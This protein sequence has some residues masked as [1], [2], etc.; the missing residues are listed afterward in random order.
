MFAVAAAPAVAC[1][2]ASGLD[3]LQKVQCVDGCDAS[4]DGGHSGSDAASTVA[5]DGSAV[6]AGGADAGPLSSPYSA[7][8][9]L[10]SPAGYWRL[11]D[12]VGSTTCHDETGNGHDG[13]VA[14]GVTLGVPGALK[15]GSN[16][17]AQFTGSG[18][19]SVGGSFTFTGAQAFTW[20]L[21]VKPAVLNANYIPFFSSMTYDT[22]DN[23][24]D[25]SYM[26][27]YSV[28]G[29]TFGFERYNGGANAVIALDSSGLVAGTWTYVVAT[30]DA[31]G[32]G[33][34]Y[35]NG[36][37]VISATGT[38]TVPAYTA[39][40]VIGMQFKG[41]IDEV[42]IYTHALSPARVTAHWMAATE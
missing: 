21:W 2:L 41:S 4:T 1:S 8:V 37:L 16:T 7:A 19:I 35:M 23:P 28:Q 17:A 30:S 31:S 25:G 14:G 26:V 9:L 22:N 20:E 10:D 36:V 24:V 33:A 39:Q 13:A 42:A 11:G 34:V 38:G 40:T 5:S 6:D 3:Q 12:A 27:S 32:N 29:D 15:A 18:S